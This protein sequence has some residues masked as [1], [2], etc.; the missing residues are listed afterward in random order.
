M[1][2]AMA[3]Q[4]KLI[5]VEEAAK[6]YNVPVTRVRQWIRTKKISRYKRPIDGAVFVNPAEIDEAMTIIPVDGDEDGDEGDAQP[7]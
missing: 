1:G 7:D 4:K 5:T 3:E 2:T 6:K